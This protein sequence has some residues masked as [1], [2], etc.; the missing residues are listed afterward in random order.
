M[1]ARR[2]R[3]ANSTLSR[4]CA[5]ARISQAGGLDE[6][7]EPRALSR[8]QQLGRGMVEALALQLPD[9]GAKLEDLGAQFQDP[10]GVRV[11]GHRAPPCRQ[12][13]GIVRRG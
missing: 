4:R 9:R 12:R 2:I 6:V 3:S 10:V 5:A 8:N 1:D 11:F 7:I 13:S